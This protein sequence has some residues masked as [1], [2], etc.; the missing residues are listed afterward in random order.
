LAACFF[1]GEKGL[2][3][4]LPNAFLR[5]YVPEMF[6]SAHISQSDSFEFGGACWENL[7]DE[8]NEDRRLINSI[9]SKSAGHW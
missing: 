2:P 9:N 3:G 5:W 1:V 8:E 6:R 4:D 7:T